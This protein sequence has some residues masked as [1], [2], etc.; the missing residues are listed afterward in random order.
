[1]SRLPSMV[2]LVS[3][4]HSATGTKWNWLV[5]PPWAM[6]A[7]RPELLPRAMSGSMD[8]LQSGSVMMFMVT[9]T[10]EGCADALWSLQPPEFM[11]HPT[12]KAML[13]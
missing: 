1:M 8:L 12:N 2:M 3:K 4:S 6:I 13:V 7:S 10:T 11:S 9:V 5:L